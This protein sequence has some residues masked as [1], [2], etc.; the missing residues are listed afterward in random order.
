[1]PTSAAAAEKSP[2]KIG[3]ENINSAA[4][5]NRIPHAPGVY[6]FLDSGGRA[7]Y[8]GKAGDLKKRL[9]SYFQKSPPPR[10]RLMLSRA[11]DVQTTVTASEGEALLLENNL[12][13]SLSPRYNILFRDDKSYPYLR[14]TSHPYPRVCFYRGA[15]GGGGDFFGPF[16]DA[17]AVR[18]SIRLLQ[19]I[20]RLRTCADSVFA[21]RAR[22]CLLYQIKRCS[23]PCVNKISPADYAADSARAKRFLNGK[24]GDVTRE[25]RARMES[26]AAQLDFESAAA[27]R[28]GL[29]AL[30]AV[31]EKHFA[32]DLKDDDADIVG[33]HSASGGAC[34]HVAMVRGGRR[35][36]EKSFFPENAD[37]C[38]S[39]EI[40]AAFVA[41]RYGRNSPP[42]AV[43]LNTMLSE[44]E[45]RGLCGK[46]G[47]KFITRPRGARLDRVKMAEK[48]AA[49]ALQLRQSRA[50]G[51]AA[52]LAA[53]RRRLH[54]SE[55]ARRVECFDASHIMGEETVA[56]CAVS[57]DGAADSSQY[58][59][60]NIRAKK[61]PGDDLA[62][63]AEAVGRRYKRLA[64][65]GGIF[66]DLILVDGG[67]NQVAA[68]RRAISEIELKN[69]PPI[70][71][72][73]KSPARKPG[74]ETLFFADGNSVR[75]PP[76]DPAL[77]LLQ[78]VRDEAHRFAIA[79]HRRRRDKKRRTSALE[80]IEGVGPSRRREL[81]ARFG[82]VKGVK[83]ASA[84]E[85]AKIEGVG[86]GLADRIYRALR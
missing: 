35:V 47:V 62:A 17:G 41:Q 72:I 61:S 21:H 71:G 84:A 26:A 50:A 38:E 27:L 39:E 44:S 37:A 9:A 81:L 51:R 5:L 58:R 33:I 70:M 34:V 43:I 40:A 28:D 82:S 32:D 78:E 66:P 23:A 25:M 63:L 56:T 4:V 6:R 12:I 80:E 60:F 16:P 24:A 3:A 45:L 48:N 13:K 52:R 46:S 22:P 59:R 31:R 86:E 57:I 36:G 67:A 83:S 68:A 19:K 75:W 42:S 1:M 76:T 30:S 79:G 77:H 14:L 69:P 11:C 7:L 49:I 54:L 65:E 73:A 55:S 10:I 15:T 20:F 29:R 64:D 18:E 2:D 53:L 8:V 74:E 85:L